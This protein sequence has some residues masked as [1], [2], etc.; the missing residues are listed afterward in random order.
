MLTADRM[1]SRN[2]LR[3]I[4]ATCSNAIISKT[5]KILWNFYGPIAMYTKFCPF[6]KK[7]KDQLLSLNISE[8]IDF[9]K[10][11]YLNAWKLLF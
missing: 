7:K 2:Y 6:W 8:V 3:E 9:E 5:K 11:G 4:A 10:C 1:Y